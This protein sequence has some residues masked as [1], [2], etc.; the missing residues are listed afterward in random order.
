MH[1]SHANMTRING[2]LRLVVENYKGR[3]D[4]LIKPEQRV[5]MMRKNWR[6]HV[7]LE[8]DL[9]FIYR[10]CCNRSIVRFARA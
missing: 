9:G 6:K 5:Q 3:H 4:A 7:Y 2:A 8:Q 10:G 1:T